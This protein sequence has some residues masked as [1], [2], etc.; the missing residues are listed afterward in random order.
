M[1]NFGAIGDVMRDNTDKASLYGVLLILAAVAFLSVMDAAM[2]VLID[3]GLA[4]LQILALRSWL[5]VPLMTI[6]AL[7]AGGV[8]AL[9]S[10]RVK[11]HLVRVMLG[12]GAPVF[13]FTS[14][15][16][17]PLAD[18]TTIFF[19]S[20]FIMTALSV[21]V[22]K[23]H[24]GPHRWTAVLL[25]FVG[26]LVA[27][28]PSG[29]ALDVGVLY[30]LGS[31]VSY[32]LFALT[33]RK[34]GT[35]EGA[36]KQVLYFHVWLGVLGAAS[37]PFT[38]RPFT[39]EEVGIVAGVGALVVVGHLCMTRAFTIAPVGLVAPFEYSALIWAG[40][41][42]FLVWG[43]VPGSALILGA[44]IIV[45]SGLYLMYRERQAAGRARPAALAAAAAAPVALITPRAAQDASTDDTAQDA[46]TNEAD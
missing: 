21:V 16:T 31:S 32:A 23:E 29:E 13:F 42:G 4:V 7:K 44:A 40:G 24:V 35:S 30:A 26:V 8:A 45:A 28:Q 27:M 18:A 20:T 34:L 38:Y 41:L 37:L 12:T 10:D 5:V 15:K 11:L 9:K 1:R 6:W 19:G 36:L 25:G 2:K 33:T 14:L 22:L 43:D 17:L 3:G 46:I 39:G